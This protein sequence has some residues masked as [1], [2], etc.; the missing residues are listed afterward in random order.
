MNEEYDFPE[1]TPEDAYQSYLDEIDAPRWNLEK[2]YP[3]F[4][5]S[6]KKR[7]EKFLED[8]KTAAGLDDFS[9][10][11]MEE[12]FVTYCRYINAEINYEPNYKNALEYIEKNGFPHPAA[13]KINLIESTFNS[14]IETL[15]E[16]PDM[17]IYTMNNDKDKI[18]KKLEEWENKYGTYP[19]EMFK[20]AYELQQ[21]AIKDKL[22]LTDENA[23]LK[24]NEDGIFYPHPQL[25]DEEGKPTLFLFNITKTYSNYWKRKIREGNK[26]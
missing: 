7:F 20:R 24:A 22:K 26:K 10:E 8:W 16:L 17:I 12:N 1:Q 3:T 4:Y 14:V 18:K 2:T 11:F 19:K 23:I 13:G 25:S 6:F 15:F 5:K 21:Q 9:K